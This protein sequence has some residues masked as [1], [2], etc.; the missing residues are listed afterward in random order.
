MYNALAVPDAP[1]VQ[2]LPRYQ[3]GQTKILVGLMTTFPTVQV[4]RLLKLI[5][6]LIAGYI[7]DSY[8]SW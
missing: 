2:S 6:I 5:M 3:D 1:T 4:V 7:P 8:L